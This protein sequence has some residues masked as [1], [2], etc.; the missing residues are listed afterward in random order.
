M[1]KKFT[2]IIL[3]IFLILV[4]GI[5]F[6]GSI[7]EYMYKRYENSK[8]FL[9]VASFDNIN[10]IEVK[11]GQKN[12]ILKKEGEE[13]LLDGYPALP[14]FI[15]NIKSA[16]LGA[17]VE[18][19]ASNNLENLDQFGLD[20]D[21]ARTFIFKENDKKIVE[22]TAG[23]FSG[24]AQS[25][26]YF[27]IREGE[28]KVLSIDGLHGNLFY[29]ELRSALIQGIERDKIT[30]VT[31]TQGKKKIVLLKDGD[32]WKVN[33]IKA[34]QS[35]VDDFLNRVSKVSAQ[36]YYQESIDKNFNAFD[37]SLE[38]VAE[39]IT[40]TLQVGVKDAGNLYYVKNDRGL[41]FLIDNETK[42]KIFQDVKFFLK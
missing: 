41:I 38:V 20:K 37:S 7:D 27:A 30:K 18:S 6:K 15:K 25:E 21:R 2:Y 26:K 3:G 9:K 32:A 31:I 35:S 39:N 16:V 12:F 34:Q 42:K 33:N 29:D 19:I 23:F 10:I 14:S 36:L 4:A 5:Y 13:W 11:Q 8:I 22:F 24:K 1:N 40:H 17:R 28:N